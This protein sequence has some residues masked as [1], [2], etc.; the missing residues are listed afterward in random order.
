M[1]PELIAI[2]IGIPVDFE[3]FISRV[4]VSDWLA[5]FYQPGLMPAEQQAALTTTWKEDYEPLVA[6]P[7][8]HLIEL[9]KN[10]G[11]QVS[12]K[13]GLSDL[14]NASA[15]KE[16]IVIFSHWKGPEILPGDVLENL[17]QNTLR[18]QVLQRPELIAQR[19]KTE[20]DKLERV[21]KQTNRARLVQRWWGSSSAPPRSVREILFAVIEESV[22]E[23]IDGIDEVVESKSVSEAKSRDA[24]DSILSDFIRPGNR[25]ELFDG[26]HGKE[27]VESVISDEFEGVLDLTMC[28]STYL[29]D[30]ISAQRK[31]RIRTVQF[32]SVQK[33]D[34]AVNCVALTL[35]IAVRKKVSYQE[36]RRSAN[37]LLT[38][39]VLDL[40]RDNK[41]GTVI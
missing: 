31:H 21:S 6:Q 26:M 38:G 7:F 14:A 9:A 15:R 24:L 4:S 17:N 27:E 35:E 29:A 40:F 28:T 23:T 3:E 39:A 36:A 13:A 10:L 19:I 12:T 22:P 1:A 37:Q 16:V 2:L 41:I 30:Y 5:K 20:L 34:W 25:L 32:P 11:I 8:R 33:F 18:F